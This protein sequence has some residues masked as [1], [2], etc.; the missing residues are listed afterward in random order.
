MT[1]EYAVV[2]HQ[3]DHERFRRFRTGYDRD[4]I[5]SL[6]RFDGV[7]NVW[8]L[9]PSTE[10]DL[11]DS[12][13][14]GDLVFFAD[15]GSAFSH[16]GVVDRKVTDRDAAIKIWGDSPRIREHKYMILFSEVSPI[17]I[18]FYE[19]CKKGGIAPSSMSTNIYVLKNTVV[20]P[21]SEI[22]KRRPAG[23]VLV[24]DDG[25]PNK[26]TEVVTRF[27]RDTDKVKQIKAAYNNVCQVCGYTIRTSQES[28]YSEVHHIHPLKDGG[29]DDFGN[30]LVLCPT[31]HVEFDYKVI[32]VGRDK[33]TIVDSKGNKI[34]DL[35][36]R[37]MH[38]LHEKNIGLHL[39]GM[40]L[41]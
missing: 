19:L 13:G 11:W 17:D 41:Q 14:R 15:A 21:S 18:P 6:D 1:R 29:N 40:G 7:D 30:M 16:L 4:I 39:A 27:I 3:K 24:S 34:G 9:G 31:H 33:K 22:A 37:K 36:V 2:I 35:T 28:R 8:A 10:P 26:K 5:K 12:I 20:H 25:A 23:T 32:G 38:R